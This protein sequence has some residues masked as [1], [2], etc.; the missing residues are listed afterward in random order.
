[1]GDVKRW[2]LKAV[3]PQCG[4]EG[5][6]R[7]ILLGMPMGDAFEAAQRVELI[8]GGCMIDLNKPRRAHG[9][10]DCGW[11]GAFKNGRVYVAP[12]EIM[13]PNSTDFF[14]EIVRKLLDE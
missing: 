5:R 14:D 10:L 6:I 7:E 1:M 2:M 8:L 12:P 9:C 4:A 13:H 11:E 3:C